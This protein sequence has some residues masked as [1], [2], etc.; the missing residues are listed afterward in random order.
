MD[1]LLVNLEWLPQPLNTSES[2]SI[3][4]RAL[5]YA[6][7]FFEAGLLS[8]EDLTAVESLVKN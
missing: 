6:R 7:R 1:N 8:R 2:D 3:T 4:P 5:D